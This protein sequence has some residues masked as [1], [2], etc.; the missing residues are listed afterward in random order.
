MSE[1]TNRITAKSDISLAWKSF[2]EILTTVLAKLKEG[3][4]LC[5]AVNDSDLYIRFSVEWEF[6]MRVETTSNLFLEESEQ[7]TA[8][9]IA[10]LLSA[11]WASPNWTPDDAIDENDKELCPNYFKDFSAPISFDTAAYLA[12][13]AFEQ[14]LQ[15]NKPNQLVYF[16]FDIDEVRLEFP[17][18][19]L[20]FE[21]IDEEDVDLAEFEVSTGYTVH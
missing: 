21:D 12:V 5:L 8:K 7:L 2:A 20:K 10:D 9:Q 15:I 3:E 11:G 17:E 14:T 4:Y 18:F 6:G 13:H 1:P 16:A 19:G